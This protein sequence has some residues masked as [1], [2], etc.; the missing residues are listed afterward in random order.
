MM[1]RSRIRVIVVLALLHNVGCHKRN[2]PVRTDTT[3]TS[4][5][6]QPPAQPPAPIDPAS[7]VDNVAGDVANTAAKCRASG[8]SVTT[9]AAYAN[10][11]PA[12]NAW[13]KLVSDAINNGTDLRQVNRYSRVAQTAD[14][15]LGAFFLA[16]K[17]D[18]L[19]TQPDYDLIGG[20]A[21]DCNALGVS[22]SERFQGQSDAIRKRAATYLVDRYTLK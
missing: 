18:N 1:I 15:A 2:T 19:I 12:Y 13:L 10:A 16:C 3:I 14:N 22:L 20:A 8:A 9:T 6:V 7:E 17:N 11:I 5:T 4:S 21:R